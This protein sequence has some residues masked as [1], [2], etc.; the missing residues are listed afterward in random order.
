MTLLT[1]FLDLRTYI[2]LVALGTDEITARYR[3]LWY[4]LLAYKRMWMN[5]IHFH[6]FSLASCARIT[7]APAP[8]SIELSSIPSILSPPPSCP[9]WQA[10]A[11]VPPRRLSRRRR[12][13]RGGCGSVPPSPPATSSSFRRVATYR[14]RTRSSAARRSSE[15][16]FV[17]PPEFQNLG[18][19]SAS[20]SS[21]TSS[22]VW[23]FRSTLFLQG[24]MYF[25]GLQFH[26][27]APNSILK[28][29]SYIVFCEAFLRI[30]PHFGL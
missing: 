1:K 4:F 30:E 18:R 11:R 23:V 25:Y 5:P 13:A 14:P 10:R 21:P 26:H 7:Q 8:K 28:I 12:T 15:L 16:P 3:A 22:E 6:A 2:T 19:A 20:Y 29:T 9:Q 27:L 24:L 17:P